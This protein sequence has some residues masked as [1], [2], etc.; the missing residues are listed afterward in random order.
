[1]WERVMSKVQ[2]CR[3]RKETR[4]VSFRDGNSVLLCPLQ[5]LGRLLRNYARNS[6]QIQTAQCKFVSC[7]HARSAHGLLIGPP[8]SSR[9]FRLGSTTVVQSKTM[10]AQSYK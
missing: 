3:T 8:K 5:T 1:M 2:V 6:T 4:E 7:T 9:W 10:H